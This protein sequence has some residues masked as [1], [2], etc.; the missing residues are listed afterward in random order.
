MSCSVVPCCLHHTTARAEAPLFVVAAA[1][2][3]AANGARNGGFVISGCAGAATEVAA[4][5]SVGCR[6]VYSVA[7]HAHFGSVVK[8]VVCDLLAVQVVAVDHSVIA[9]ELIVV[10]WRAVCNC[11][12][13]CG[14]GHFDNFLVV[15]VLSICSNRIYLI[16]IFRWCDVI[17]LSFVAQYHP[18]LSLPVKY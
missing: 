13:E 8:P 16:S 15:P 2:V 14:R 10:S 3:S 6:P 4:W 7:H 12:V 5:R 9:N 17:F 18:F 11:V 1:A